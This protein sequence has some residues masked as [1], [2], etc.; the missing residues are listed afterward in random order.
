MPYFSGNRKPKVIL[1]LDLHDEECFGKTLYASS[2]NRTIFK[3]PL[4]SRL[5][6]DYCSRYSTLAIVQ[7]PLPLTIC[8]SVSNVDQP[9]VEVVKQLLHQVNLQ[10]K[11]E[12]EVD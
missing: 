3:T 12:R 11:I 4:E 2:G 10:I 6:R 1:A 8:D 9:R 7:I 5:K